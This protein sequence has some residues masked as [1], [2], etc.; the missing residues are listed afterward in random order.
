[1]R[2]SSLQPVVMRTRL[3]AEARSDSVPLMKPVGFSLSGGAMGEERLVSAAR[4]GGADGQRRARRRRRSR[5]TRTHFFATSMIL[6]TLASLKPLMASSF[7]LGTARH[8][9]Q[10]AAR[11]A[12]R[13][14]R[15]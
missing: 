12:R 10:R 4:L 9:G 6:S 11:G 13:A 5:G 8:C 3:L 15:G 7:L 2:S 1:M 14:E